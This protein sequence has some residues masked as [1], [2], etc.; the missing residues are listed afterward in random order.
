MS[1]GG[2]LVWDGDWWG[3][4]VGDGEGVLVGIGLRSPD[5]QRGL[6]EVDDEQ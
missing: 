3:G 6:L 4:L 1:E 2:V 5:F